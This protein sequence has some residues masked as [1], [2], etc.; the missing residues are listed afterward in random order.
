MIPLIRPEI[1][2]SAEWDH[3]FQI[4]RKTGQ[5]SNFGPCYQH[6]QSRLYDLTKRYAV[7]CQNGTSALQVAL[8]A[9][10]RR[11]DKVIVPDFTH[12][13]TVIS[14]KMA[15][16]IPVIAPVDRETWTLTAEEIIKAKYASGFVVVSPFGYPVDFTTY[17]M[18]CEQTGKKVIY[19]LAGA[20]GVNIATKAPVMFSMHA[21]KNLSVGEGGLAMFHEEESALRAQKLTSFDLDV[22]RNAQSQHGMNTKMDEIHCAIALA[23]LDKSDQ[24]K[25]RIEHKQY[26]IDR[27]KWE[28]GLEAPENMD[29]SA[30]S[31]CVIGGVKHSDFTGACASLGITVRKYFPLLSRMPGFST[32]ALTGE[33]D[34]FFQTCYALPSDVTDAEADEVISKIG[35]ILNE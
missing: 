12:P 3:Y 18:I 20:W 1:P 33:C 34:E 9:T 21:T 24:M 5:F 35:G 4:S 31:L 23:Q 8:M 16:L 7:P 27:Y 11:G 10:F 6:L 19:D 26:L 28:L 25:R 32:I 13:G 2:E 22:N 17:D 14:V 15:G 30:P 29:N